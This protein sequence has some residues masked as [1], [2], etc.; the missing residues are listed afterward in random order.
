MIM[1]FPDDPLM[2]MDEKNG[3][4][5]ITE[6]T[7]VG[8][9]ETF[10]GGYKESFE[11][12]V[13]RLW[14]HF[15][16]IQWPDGPYSKSNPRNLHISMQLKIGFKDLSSLGVV[17]GDAWKMLAPQ[18]LPNMPMFMMAYE[19][20]HSSAITE[21]TAN[22]L[23]EARAANDPTIMDRPIPRDERGNIP[24]SKHIG[25]RVRA[26]VMDPREIIERCGI[27]VTVAGV[28]CLWNNQT[29]PPS[30]EKRGDNGTSTAAAAQARAMSRA[31]GVYCLSEEAKTVDEVWNNPEAF[32]FVIWANAKP[33]NN[34]FEMVDHVISP[35]DGDILADYFKRVL[36]KRHTSLTH[37]EFMDQFDDKIAPTNPLRETAFVTSDNTGRLLVYV[38][39]IKRS[40][41]TQKERQFATI[42]NDIYAI[43][44]KMDNRIPGIRGAGDMQIVTTT[45]E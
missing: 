18:R 42:S 38:W 7:K 10:I 30:L 8:E 5:I 13:P 24:I 36:V 45:S 23:D 1:G 34:S 26:I 31:A 44:H 37:D 33:S 17:S 6:V 11:A 9:P 35:V 16:I 41:V 43:G 12:A 28:K 39:A 19:D 15:T 3:G 32:D 14:R 40:Y 4:A 25:V 29:K 27:P 20:L 21:V 2:A 22:L